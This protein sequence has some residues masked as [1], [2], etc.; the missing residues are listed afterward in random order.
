MK[1]YLLFVAS[2]CVPLLAED[3][4]VGGNKVKSSKYAFIARLKTARGK[5]TGSLVTNDLILTAKHCFYDEYRY[6]GPDGIATFNDYNSTSKEE[7]EFTVNMTLFQSYDNSDLALAKLH[8]KVWLP[9]VKISDRQVRVGDSVKSVGYGMHG[10][11][12]DDGHLRDI[13]LEISHVNETIIGT[14]VGENNEGP[15]KGDSGGPLLV[16]CYDGWEVVASLKGH[17][18]NCD[19]DTK[20][21]PHDEWNSVRVINPADLY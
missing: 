10:F 19:F 5:C 15:C 4:H 17:G 16:S 11:K 20:P 1:L 18:Y 9:P 12:K 2:M 8:H 13:D 3:Y 21:S 7:E 14:K 6:G